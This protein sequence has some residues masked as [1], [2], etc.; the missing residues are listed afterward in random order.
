[1]FG[2]D[3]SLAG[4]ME[5]AGV[6]VAVGLAL[7]LGLRHASDPD[8]LAAV[9]T[10]IAT[11]P[12]GG[13]SRAGRLGLAWGFGHASTLVLFGLPIILFRAY[14]P[15][16][17]QHAAE[18]LVGLMIMALAIRL[19]IRWRAGNFHAHAHRHGHLEHRHLHPH[20]EEVPA[21][22]HGAV[23]EHSHEPEAVL[24]RSPAQ[25]YGIGLVHGMGGS[26]GVAVLLVAGIPSRPEAIAALAVLAIGTAVSMA[27][28]SSGFGYV[29][30][31]G[32]VM[33]R[34]L[35]LAPALGVASLLFGAWYTLGA[36]GAVPYFL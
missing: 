11:E 20:G 10:L 13:T 36:L 18:A 2:L 32:P 12:Q 21:H 26:A 22:G 33:R 5:G 34:L 23:H 25:A 24:G 28:L 15:E 7:L 4:L 14:L 30:T 8:H 16:S 3:Q 35:A 9:S 1:M 27:I 31:R 29:I 17:L 19:L 6:F